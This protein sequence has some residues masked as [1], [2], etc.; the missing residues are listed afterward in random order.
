MRILVDA[1]LLNGGGIGR[2]SRE[3]SQRWL[4]DPRVSGIHFL[5]FSF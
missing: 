2:F 5:G 1:R 4:A 3:I